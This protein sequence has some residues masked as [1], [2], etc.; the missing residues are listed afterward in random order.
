LGATGVLYAGGDMI[1]QKDDRYHLLYFYFHDAELRTWPHR[2]SRADLR[3]RSAKK[4]CDGDSKN[5]SRNEAKNAL[6]IEC[7]RL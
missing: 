2:H 6:V 4:V 5:I 3:L 7:D 1:R